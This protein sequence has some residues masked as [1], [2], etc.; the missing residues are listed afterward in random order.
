MNG[1]S[2]QIS[3]I[4]CYYGGMR[5]IDDVSLEV[6][7]GEIVAIIGANGAGKST[8]MKSVAGLVKPKSGSIKFNGEE[9][10][11]TPANKIIYKGISYVPEGRRLFANLSVRENL[12]LGA[13]SERDRKLIDERIDAVFELFPI[14]KDRERQLARTMSGGEQQMC[15][16]ARGM[17]SGPK[18]LMLDEL[19][20]GLMPSLVEKVLES[21]AEINRK[22]VTVLLVEQ[23]VQEALEIASRGY[24]IKAGRI[25]AHGT[26]NELLGSD[27][28]RKAYLGM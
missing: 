16:I 26:S 1:E 8:L 19:S 17:M 10:S 15:A 9:I 13:F 11:G 2:L 14:L 18:L 23:M 3:D 28:V 12:E 27:D 20:L 4:S 21:V 7:S 24:V 5:A 6:N 22:G 25:A